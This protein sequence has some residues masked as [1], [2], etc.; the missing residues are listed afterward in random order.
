MIARRTASH[1]IAGA[2]CVLALACVRNND[3]LIQELEASSGA[4]P[5]LDAI[6]ETPLDPA[7][8]LSGPNELEF[9]ILHA[10]LPFVEG[11]INGQPLPLLLDTGSS[12]VSLTGPGARHV[13]LYLPAR[14]EVR[15]VTP[16]NESPHRLGAYTS[17]TIGTF[18][19]GAGAAAVPRRESHTRH[20]GPRIGN[21]YAIVGSTILSHFRVTFDFAKRRVR[22]SRH[23]QT[24]RPGMLLASVRVGTQT[25]AM[26]V[27]SGA[28]RLTLEPWAALE[29]GLIDESTRIRFEKR[30]GATGSGRR[31]SL[32]LDR[33]DVAGREFR[34]VRATVLNTFGEARQEGRRVAGLL[35]LAGLGKLVWTLDY[36]TRELEVR[37]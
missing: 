13:G 3:A 11:A 26:L 6:L 2:L 7:P 18:E 37:D 4:R 25:Y 31:K 35:G 33:V 28:H 23:H 34:R 22:L 24:P 27:D 12:A 32:R 30:E 17:M 20:G 9:S 21:R 36:A 5:T 29:L 19:L 1:A 14:P 8:F 10:D 16:G 15:I